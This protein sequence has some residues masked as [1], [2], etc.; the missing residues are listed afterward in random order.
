M[1]HPEGPSGW[2]DVPSQPRRNGET[3]A[4]SRGGEI[5]ELLL[6][7]PVQPGT[8]CGLAPKRKE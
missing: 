4:E 2:V 8:D 6:S 5:L 3:L 7:T 1:D